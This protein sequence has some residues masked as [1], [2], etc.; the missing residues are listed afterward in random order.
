[1]SQRDLNKLSLLA[2]VACDYYERGFSQDEIAE[3]LHLSRTRVSRLIKEAHERGIVR[4]T[5][6]YSFERH[7]ELE[8]RFKTRF[9]LRDVRILNNRGRSPALIHQDVGKLAA[10]YLTERLKKN[11]IL[12]TSWG[13]SLSDVA[14][15]LQPQARQA[16]VV[17]LVGSVPCSNPSATPQAIVTALAEKLGGHGNYL[18]L[19]LFIEDDYVRT[20]I[21]QD[22]NNARILNQSLLCDMVLTGVFDVNTLASNE[23]WRSY[24]SSEMYDEILNKG[25]AG[26][27]L[28]QFYD[29]NGER[30]DCAWNRKCVSMSFEAL[31][32][33][34]DVVAIASSPLKAPALLAAIRGKLIKTLVIDGTTATRILDSVMP[35]QVDSVL[36]K[37]IVHDPLP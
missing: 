30:I 32:G 10:D 12:G 5:I 1:M 2:E 20:V 11:M 19:P 33:I 8:E 23:F 28:A 37:A 36:N 34:D 27:I 24:M 9:Q 4:I 17:Q 31:K 13:V 6:D 22:K 21:C 15:Q 14:A 3:R 35:N 25:A 29:R 16:E 18:N 26:A 7:Y